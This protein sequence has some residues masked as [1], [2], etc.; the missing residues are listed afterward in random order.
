MHTF[1]SVL[2]A[3]FLAAL[4]NMD[5]QHIHYLSGTLNTGISKVREPD[6]RFNL[7]YGGQF[8]YVFWENPGW[9]LKYGLGFSSQASGIFEYPL[10]FDVSQEE[11]NKKTDMSYNRMDFY[12]PLQGFFT[13]YRYRR[14]S[15][16]ALAGLELNYSFREIYT[17]DEYGK[18]KVPFDDIDK[19]IKSAAMI[20]IGYQKEFS[21]LQYLN[22][23]PS[24]SMELRAE[25][26]FYAIKLNAEFIYALD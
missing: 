19:R 3:L 14:E 13:F 10:L 11:L 16:F 25:R 7:T 1:K 2:V 8:S 21:R 24:F 6:S 12:I 9:Y 23:Y 15:F 20:G 26:P 18:V 22:L 5:A 4:S 17:H